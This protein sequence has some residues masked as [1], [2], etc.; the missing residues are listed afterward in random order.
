MTDWR[1]GT[2]LR[3]LIATAGIVVSCG[4]SAAAQNATAGDGQNVVA[5]VDG[6]EITQA[7]LKRYSLETDPATVKRLD[8]QVYEHRDRMLYRLVGERLLQ[9]EALLVNQTIEAFLDAALSKRVTAVTEE[10][11][12]QVYVQSPPSR[13]DLPL[14]KARPMIRRYLEMQRRE[15]AKEEYIAELRLKAKDRVSLRLDAP[16]QQIP[17]TVADP[18][19]GAA[20]APVEIVEFSD[21]QCPYC[22]QLQPVLKELLS[23][24]DGQVRLVWKDAPLPNHAFARGAAEAARCASDQGRFWDYHDALFNGQSALTPADLQKHAAAL[25]MDTTAFA[26]CLEKGTHRGAILAAANVASELGIHATPTL[27]INGRPLA[28]VASRTEYE[29]I[30]QQEIEKSKR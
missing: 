18:S 25:G 29:R 30:V 5:V 10:E 6:Q 21:F 8:R 4:V 24:F 28:G 7:D 9:R 15:Q 17:T 20:S 2:N 1:V 12:R 22:K 27:F 13:A 14:D 26:A 23:K 19:K 11:V 16:R 3:R